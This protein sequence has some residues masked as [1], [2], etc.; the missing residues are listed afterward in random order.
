MKSYRVEFV[1]FLPVILSGCISSLLPEKHY[2]EIRGVRNPQEWDLSRGLQNRDPRQ[3][4]MKAIPNTYQPDCNGH[5]NSVDKIG[6]Y[7]SKYVTSVFVRCVMEPYDYVPEE[8]VIEYAFWKTDAEIKAAGL[9]YKQIY[10]IQNGH[11]K[12][13]DAAAVNYNDNILMAMRDVDISKIPADQ[14]HRIVLH[15][16]SDYAT[17]YNYPPKLDKGWYKANN[18]KVLQY[19]IMINKDGSNA[20]YPAYDWKNASDGHWIP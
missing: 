19:R 18:D 12:G 16:K 13:E 5:A 6:T 14:W 4:V 17:K 3:L 20:I 7:N 2:V 15:P 11:V 8:I 9:D 1:F 10:I